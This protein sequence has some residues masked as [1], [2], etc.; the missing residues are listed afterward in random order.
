[1][2]KYFFTI[3][4]LSASVCLFAQEVEEDKTNSEKAKEAVAAMKPKSSGSR[5]RLVV[6]LTFDQWLHDE[7]G[8]K[9]KWHSRGFNTYFMYDIQLGK[10]KK[11]FSVAP[12]LGISTSSIFHN[13][14]VS[15]DTVNGTTFTIDPTITDNYKKNKFGLTYVDIPLELRFRST[16]NAKNK[17]WKFALGFKAGVLIDSKVKVKQEDANGNMKIYK[18]KRYSDLNRF[19]YGATVRFGYGPFNFFGFYSLAKLFDKGMGP[20]ITPISMGISINGL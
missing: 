11:L 7:N 8:L 17:S 3:L 12:G 15:E 13:A 16:P 4:M 19:R 2:K 1:M 18:E 6:D 20:D 10:K 14:I 5:D 9:L